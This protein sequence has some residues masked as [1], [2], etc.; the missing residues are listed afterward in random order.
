MQ[1]PPLHS[2][3]KA[4]TVSVVGPVKLEFAGVAKSTWNLKRRS[5]LVAKSRKTAGSPAVGWIVPS[6]SEGSRLS[7]A[8]LCWKQIMV[9][10]LPASMALRL[11]A[12]ASAPRKAVPLALNMLKE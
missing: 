11:A 3:V 9:A 10:A 4:A 1:A 7:M 12:Q 8:L 2:G 5:E 6:I